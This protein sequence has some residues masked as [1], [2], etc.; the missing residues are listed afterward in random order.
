MSTSTIPQHYPDTWDTSW[1][2]ALQT[3]DRR[4]AQFAMPD[5][6]TGNRKWYNIG[7]T[8]EF[9]QKTA[10]YPETTHVDYTSSKS[11][12]Y[13]TEWDAPVLF[14]EWDDAFLD[15]I[16]LPTS[17]VM[18]D[19]AAAFA[20]LEDEKVRDAIQGTRITGETG[21]TTET[22]PTG[23]VIAVDYEDG[24]T[25]TALTWA[26]IVQASR[27]MSTLRIPLDQR[28]MAIS[29]YQV[30]DLMS[31]AQA[32]DQDYASTALIRE[33][34]INGAKWAGFTWIEYPD[35]SYDA[36]DADAR[37]CLAF[38][39]PDI[40]LGSSGY[41][42]YM[43]VLPERSHALQLRPSVRLGAGRVRNSSVIV[44]CLEA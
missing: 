6:I 15:S 30:K 35:L 33:G 11:W 37:Q 21:T 12:V 20:R 5:T 17:R 36:A 31:I 27:L 8:I 24:S 29:E 9:K 7:D 18:T 42:S 10:R 4:L 26:K 14:D 28:Y 19:Q 1:K 39:G 43:D 34:Q 44:K 13:T 22:F 25:D 41:K 23:Q 38:Y 16:V 32:T 40:I 3:T 2:Q